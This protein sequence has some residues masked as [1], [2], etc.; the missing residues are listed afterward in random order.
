M[1]GSRQRRGFIGVPDFTILGQKSRH[2]LKRRQIFDEWANTENTKLRNL[3]ISREHK[4]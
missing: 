1:K 4:I 2:V 3:S